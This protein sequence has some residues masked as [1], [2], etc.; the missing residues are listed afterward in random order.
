[1]WNQPSTV[2]TTEIPVEKAEA[3]FAKYEEIVIPFI[4][5]VIG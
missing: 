1:M 5:E 3:I 2:Q 4:N